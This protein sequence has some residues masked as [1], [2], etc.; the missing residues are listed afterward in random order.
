MQNDDLNANAMSKDV[1]LRCMSFQPKY[2]S[3]ALKLEASGCYVSE[4][5]NL[6]RVN[7]LHSL[8]M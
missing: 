2:F 4:Q 7:L 3:F 1:P 5:C 8:V 6:T